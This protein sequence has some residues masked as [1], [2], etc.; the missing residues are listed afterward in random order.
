RARLTAPQWVQLLKY[1]SED[2]RRLAVAQFTVEELTAYFQ[3][4][5]MAFPQLLALLPQAILPHSKWSVFLAEK[6]DAL[7]PRGAAAMEAVLEAG[8]EVAQ[9]ERPAPRADINQKQVLLAAFLGLYSLQRNKRGRHLSCWGSLFRA[10][11]KEVKMA[12]AAWLVGVLARTTE[13]DLQL[14]DEKDIARRVAVLGQ[15]RLGACLNHEGFTPANV[16][17]ALRC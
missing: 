16:T 6:R 17:T 8:A 2:Q 11:P 4:Y 10:P 14:D 9:A 5:P 7:K 12:D 1:V 13:V 3:P 15:G